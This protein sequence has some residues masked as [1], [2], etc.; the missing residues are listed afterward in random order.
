VEHAAGQLLDL[1]DG[2]A[3]EPS[4]GNAVIGLAARLPSGLRQA[5]VVKSSTRFTVGALVARKSSAKAPP[6]ATSRGSKRR[7]SGAHPFSEA[8]DQCG[9]HPA[10][11]QR[12]PGN[13]FPVL[14]AVYHH[15]PPLPAAGEVKAPVPTWPR[16]AL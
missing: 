6:S 1:W 16:S 3:L 4:P 15:D 9:Q 14:S 2:E 10:G 5:A 7:P 11:V 12:Q 8:V 13:G